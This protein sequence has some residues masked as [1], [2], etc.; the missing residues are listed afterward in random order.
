MNNL[1]SDHSTEIYANSTR[2]PVYANENEQ[3]VSVMLLCYNDVSENKPIKLRAKAL[4]VI[5]MV[6]LC[7]YYEN[8][9]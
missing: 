4:F 7:F 1:S 9:R 5:K 6:I 3:S 8:V 2:F